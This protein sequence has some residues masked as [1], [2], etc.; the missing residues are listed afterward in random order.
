MV[1][2]CLTYVNILKFLRSWIHFLTIDHRYVDENIPK[3]QPNPFP[4]PNRTRQK[5]KK[6]RRRKC[7]SCLCHS[8]ICVIILLLMLLFLYE[9]NELFLGCLGW[10]WI[11]IFGC[12]FLK[13][14]IVNLYCLLIVFAKNVIMKN[15]HACIQVVHGKII[16]ENKPLEKLREPY[17]NLI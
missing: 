17:S 12:D 5:S 16:K 15:F 4:T 11:D 14:K 8:F 3:N 2:R 13:W 7:L 6:S 1:C 9:I 10:Y